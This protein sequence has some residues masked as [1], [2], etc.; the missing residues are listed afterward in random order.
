MHFWTTNFHSI[1][2]NSYLFNGLIKQQI[3]YRITYLLFFI[4]LKTIFEHNGFLC[5]TI[6]NTDCNKQIW[7]YIYVLYFLHLN[8]FFSEA[9][10]RFHQ[11][12]KRSMA[13]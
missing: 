12:P 5:Y 10:R 1:L 9:V 7:T 6:Y 3:Y 2:P 8:T 13:Q 11:T 4:I